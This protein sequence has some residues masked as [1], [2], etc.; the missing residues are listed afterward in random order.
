MQPPDAVVFADTDG[1]IRLETPAAA[2]G[3]LSHP[4]PMLQDFPPQIWYV[5]P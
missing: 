4:A 5:R 1:V 3:A 2:R